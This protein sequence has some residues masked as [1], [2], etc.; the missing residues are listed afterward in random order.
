MHYTSQI[1]FLCVLVSLLFSA[2]IDPEGKYN[3]F[4]ERKSMFK[5]PDMMME[6]IFMALMRRDPKRQGKMVYNGNF[7]WNL[8]L[9]LKS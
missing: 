8:N 6:E 3:A 2:C 7:P 1:L 5:G 4:E 9:T